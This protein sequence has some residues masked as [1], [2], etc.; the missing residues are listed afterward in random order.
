MLSRI[1]RGSQP[2]SADA[3]AWLMRVVPATVSREYRV[4]CGSRPASRLARAMIGAAAF[5]STCGTT[6]RVERPVEPRRAS[7]SRSVKLM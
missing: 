1:G 3:F 2:S 5:A 6:S 7:A 4:N